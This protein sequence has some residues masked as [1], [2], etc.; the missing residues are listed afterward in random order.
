MVLNVN[1]DTTSGGNNS[2]IVGTT[3]VPY[4]AFSD[5]WS[6][7]AQ[8][9]KDNTTVYGY[10]LMNEPHDM[11]VPTTT[12]NYLT[13]A[14]V[15]NMM[16]QAIN[17]IR[18]YDHLHWIL[19]NLDSYAGAQSFVGQYGTDPT[20]WLTD[21]FNLL[22]YSVHYYFDNDHSGTYANAFASSNN[23]NILADVMSFF[24]WGKEH[25]I[26]THVGEY[27]V[28]NTSSW[29]VC[30]TTFLD[31]CNM[32]D[33]AANHWAAG[34]HYSSITTLQ[35]TGSA[36]NLTD[37]LQMATIGMQRYL[38]AGFL[39]NPPLTVFGNLPGFIL[40]GKKLKNPKT[41]LREPIFEKV[42]F[43][44]L[45]GKTTRDISHLKEKFTL[46]FV[47]LTKQ[48]V[49]DLNSIIDKQVPVTLSINGKNQIVVQTTVFPYIGAIV[50]DVVGSDYR[51][52]TTLELIE[53]T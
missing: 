28:P 15:T 47:N 2:Y 10:D 12:S 14:T 39:P 50:Y 16:Q 41:F 8:A 51:A 34:D 31:L 13:T 42:D 40:D 17:A 53:E 36:P 1:G 27:G 3:N 45:T 38:G 25:N 20:P 52:S 6:R 9:Y 43:T 48:Q 35:P 49:D 26:P 19:T 33:V 24:A 5:L 32:Y 30:L 21:S 11:T 18:V 7:I 4:S 23:N 29:Q 37:L 46:G 44:M 22:I